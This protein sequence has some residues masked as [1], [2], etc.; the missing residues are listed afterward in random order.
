MGRLGGNLREFNI[1]KKLKQEDTAKRHNEN[2]N[3]RKNGFI[4]DVI[5]RNNVPQTRQ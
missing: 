2:V 3:T 4:N 5:N 1:N